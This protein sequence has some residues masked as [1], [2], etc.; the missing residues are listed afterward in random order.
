[1]R[2]FSGMPINVSP[3]ALKDTDQ[4][5][6]PA[7]KNRSRRIHKKL[8]RK[9]GGEFKQ[10]PA[11]YRTPYGWVAHPVLYAGLMAHLAVDQLSDRNP[12]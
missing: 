10:A 12:W 11:I 8:V 7:S 9:F 2:L 1:M 5:L 3:F 4:R 6:F